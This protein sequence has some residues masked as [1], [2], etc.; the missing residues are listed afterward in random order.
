MCFSAEASFAVGTVLIPAG[1]YCTRRAFRIDCS[2]L[3]L[4]VIPFFFGIQQFC[5]GAVWIGLRRD[6]PPLTQA[7]SLGFLFFALA[8][9][10]F[11]IPLSAFLLE[12]QPR[13]KV[14][15]GILTLLSLIWSLILYVPISQYPDQWLVT[16]VQHH[17]I[18]YRYF[19]LPV[20]QIISPP[21]LRV[22]YLV[23]IALPLTIGS[24]RRGMA[25]GVL[26]AASALVSHFAFAYAF[27]SVW[28]FFAALLALYLCHFFW[29]LPERR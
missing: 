7:G 23:T 19:N 26:L 20:Y 4:A 27:V 29:R 6:D 10:P 18:Q 25:F 9:W 5:E 17:S 16:G 13:R 22:C 3:G 21:L 8:F 12:K 2:H 28:C 24:D 1:I 14:L 11:W 15:M